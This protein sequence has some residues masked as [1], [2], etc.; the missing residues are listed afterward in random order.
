MKLFH[1]LILIPFFAQC[2]VHAQEIDLDEQSDSIVQELP[3]WLVNFSNLSRED[4]ALYL[5]TFNKAKAAYSQSQWIPCITYLADCEMIFQGNPNVWN[6]RACCLMEQKYF[7]EAE[8]ELQRAIEALP[9]DP[10]TIMNLANLQLAQGKHEESIA[11]IHALRGVLPPTTSQELHDVLDFRELLCLVMLDKAEQARELIK[12][13]SPISDTP[14][15]YY[16]QA[17]FAM[18]EG[19]R[20]EATRCIRI[21]NRIFAKTNAN[22][23]YQRS[24]NLSGLAQKSAPAAPAN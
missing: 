18:A 5:E 11:T 17:A 2:P 6:L 20:T 12:H 13:L 22:L 3:A 7:P 8:A 10:V 19:N 23:P 24:L 14:L 4:R 9:N 16:S 15:Y 1:F 21:V